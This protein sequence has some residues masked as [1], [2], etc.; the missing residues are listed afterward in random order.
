MTSRAAATRYARALFDVALKQGDINQVER[1]LSEFTGILTGNQ[2]LM[3]VL[4]NPAVPT[5]RKRATIEQLLAQVGPVSP[6]VSKLLLLLADRDRLVLLPELIRAY[7]ERLMD[8]AKIVRAEV[9]TATA[10]PADRLAALQDGLAAAT[11]RKVH[12][13]SKVD[14]AI[15][16][17]AVARVG[18]T[19]YD[20][21]V[22]TQ[23]EK[24]KASLSQTA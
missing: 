16:G 20:G 12:L 10:L 5:P 21:S 19:I 13:E 15:I 17:G 3:R 11:G 18:S 24:L 1:E 9:T 7:R 4:S 8:H 14:P 23:L 22:T 2:L 6:I